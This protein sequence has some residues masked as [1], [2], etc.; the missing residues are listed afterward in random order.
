MPKLSVSS[1]V[2]STRHNPTS[3]DVIVWDDHVKQLGLRTRDG[4][5]TWIVQTRV[6]GKTKRRTLESD[7][8][9]SAYQARILA[10]Q[11]LDEL[12]QTNA[13]SNPFVHME[14]FANI[15]LEDCIGRWKA[16][17]T[18]TNKSAIRNYII[19]QF[20]KKAVVEIE[21][22]DVVVWYHQ[23][24]RAPATRN[25]VLSVLST[26]MQHA[27]ITGIRPSHS[28]PCRYMRKRQSEFKAE[29]L[30]EKG[31]AKLAKALHCLEDQFPMQVAFVKFLMFTGCRKGEAKAAL[32]SQLELDRIVLPDSK[33]G[34]K[35]IWFGEPAR[36]VLK[37]LPKTGSHI[38]AGSHSNKFANE[39]ERD[40]TRLWKEIRNKLGRPKFRLHDLRHSFASVAVNMAYDLKTI[41]GLLGHTDPETTAA[42]A[43]LNKKTVREAG[44]RVGEHFE[45]TFAQETPPKEPRVARKSVER[46]SVFM[47]FIKSKQ[48]LD[49]FCKLEGLSPQTF[50]Q[51]LRLWR[52]NNQR[53]AAK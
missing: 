7:D 17:S 49:Q 23:I 41:G 29:Y 51:E 1:A 36:K 25:R 3:R 48:K 50:R 13:R 47:R 33:T 44:D 53:R 42:Y 26:I 16:G 21:H 40:L 30:D 28:N 38:F 15:C 52:K 31:Y 12:K 20:G 14:D 2:K 19:P 32:W 6:D 27:E 43:H 46:H 35:T 18:K 37:A 34:P 22:Q 45:R 9:V 8:G 5:K 11:T 39:F 24:E 4:K 10:Q